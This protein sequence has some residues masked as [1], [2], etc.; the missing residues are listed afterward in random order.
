MT[1]RV[2]DMT[3]EE[4]LSRKARSVED[5]IITHCQDLCRLIMSEY[6]EARR[7]ELDVYENSQPIK[8]EMRVTLT[9]TSGPHKDQVFVIK[10]KSKNYPLIGRS[11]LDKFIKDG[12]SLSKDREVSSYHGK[13][14]I[15]GGQLKYK[16]T[17]S[18]N[19]SYVNNELV[20]DEVTLKTGDVL[21]VG[22]SELT[23]EIKK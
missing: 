21:R 9:C 18:M 20:E 7:K 4:F 19:H 14:F 22:E 16:D 10:P 1:T 15:R 13:F 23:I 2:E 3:V 11:T 12:V 5:A 8:I 17:N 6:E